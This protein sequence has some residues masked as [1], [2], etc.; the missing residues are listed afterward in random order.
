M[1]YGYKNTTNVG[2]SHTSGN[3][4]LPHNFCSVQ[5]PGFYFLAFSYN[6]KLTPVFHKIAKA[7]ECRRDFARRNQLGM[8]TLTCQSLQA[9]DSFFQSVH[10]GPPLKCPTQDLSNKQKLLHAFEIEN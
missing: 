4:P 9:A 7:I 6:S 5:C 8:T 2:S 3:S 1:Y 10:G